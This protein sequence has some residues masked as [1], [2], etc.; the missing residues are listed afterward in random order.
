MVDKSQDSW[1]LVSKMDNI[2]MFK[3]HKDGLANISLT[4]LKTTNE[5]EEKVISL[6]NAINKAIDVSTPR[7]RFCPTSVL[8]FI[9]KCK[10]AQIRAR[11]L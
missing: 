11:K 3:T 10:D 1:R 2:A 4:T 8:G 6:V 7:A 9:K 5:L